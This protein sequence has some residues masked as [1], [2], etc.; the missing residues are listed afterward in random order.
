MKRDFSLIRSNDDDTWYY[1]RLGRK[2]KVGD[3]ILYQEPSK[4]RSTITNRLGLIS[5]DEDGILYVGKMKS[6]KLVN[7]NDEVLGKVFGYSICGPLIELGMLR[8]KYGI[9]ILDENLE[10]SM[11]SGNFR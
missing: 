3:I 10:E 11:V 6:P 8:G 4:D 2:P 7:R 9:T 1:D 5:Y